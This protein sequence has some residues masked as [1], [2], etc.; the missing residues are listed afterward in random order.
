MG[1]MRQHRQVQ[2]AQVIHEHIVQRPLLPFG[3]PTVDHLSQDH[4]L[5]S[6]EFPR[7]FQLPQ[8][9]VNAIGRF[10]HILNQ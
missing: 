4:A 3:K 7:L 2:V 10:V 5:E 6:L 1:A 9:S 8:H